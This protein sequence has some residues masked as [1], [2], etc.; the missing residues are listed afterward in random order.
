MHG[1]RCYVKLA[2]AAVLASLALAAPAHAELVGPTGS[3]AL[4]AIGTDGT[5]YVAIVRGNQVL[6]A[7]RGESGWSAQSAYSG[8]A[9]LAGLAVGPGGAFN[10]LLE[11][12][13]GRWL[14]LV[15]S[16]SVT[17]IV[18]PSTKVGLLGPAGLALDS[19]GAP[20][21]AYTAMRGRAQPKYGGIPTYLRLARGQGN[22]L[23]T[24]AITRRGFPQSYGLPAAAP[25][26]VNGRIHV[27]ETYTSAAI[28]WEPKS[29]GGWIGQYLFISLYGSPVGPVA[30]VAGPGA[31]VW[32]AWTQDYPEFG[33]THVMLTFRPSD[34]VPDDVVQHGSLVSLAVA[35][36]QPEL[37]ANDW[38]DVGGSR[39]YA[40]LITAHFG[41]AVELDGRLLGYAAAPS[42]HRQ[43]VLADPAGV[44]WYNL[45]GFPSVHVSMT[46]TSDGR[47][48]GRVDGALGG[49]VELYRERPGQA[50]QLVATVPLAGDGTFS[51]HDDV[52]T[53]PTLYRAVYRDPGTGIPFASLTRTPVGPG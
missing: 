6:L 22:Q 33:E 35:G 5:P 31:G 18:R 25:V 32:S 4:L 13:N 53:S 26:L 51:G 40:G 23:R 21:V 48:S 50:R 41:K 52:P 9:R 20:V 47:L 46:A 3:D 29:H 17:P 49:D 34:G 44:E 14:T 11:D 1:K 7:K 8:P 10:V 45:A 24:S 37:A 43:V 38:V 27:V 12:P 39:D 19:Q 16:S 36:G 28:E 15:T 42:G 2:L 30:A